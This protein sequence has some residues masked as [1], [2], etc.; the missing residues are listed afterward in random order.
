MVDSFNKFFKSLVESS[1]LN[2]SRDLNIDEVR[3][4]ISKINEYFFTN[5]EGIG[6]TNA[7]GEKFEYFS[8]FHKFWEKYHCEVLNP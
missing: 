8:E 6:F 2:L 3:Y 4:I 7:L 5:Y 1:G